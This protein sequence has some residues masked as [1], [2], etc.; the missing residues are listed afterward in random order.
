MQAISFKARLGKEQVLK[1]SVASGATATISVYV[2]K[3]SAGDGTAYTGN[4]PRLIVRKNLAAGITSDTVLATA[5]AATGSW[6]QLS[7]TTIAVSE[8]CSLEF[9]RRLRRHCWLGK[10]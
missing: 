5:A 2:R 7:G 8:D 6:E 10:Y 9:F 4:Q 1:T 3:S